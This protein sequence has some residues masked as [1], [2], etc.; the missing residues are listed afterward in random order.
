MLQQN[1]RSQNGISF[2][3]RRFVE[4]QCR[5]PDG[6]EYTDDEIIALESKRRKKIR[7]EYRPLWFCFSF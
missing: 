1:H 3:R 7:Y 4:H 6:P 2:I 5:N